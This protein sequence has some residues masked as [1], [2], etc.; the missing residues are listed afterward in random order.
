[1]THI[2]LREVKH[3]AMLARISFSK[4]ELTSLKR[5]LGGILAYVKKLQAMP[6]S[7]IAFESALRGSEAQA[8]DDDETKTLAS[9]DEMLESVPVRKGRLV[10]APKIRRA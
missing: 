4:D 5:D 8:R 6:R 2:T 7:S 9:A 10:K 3:S 1:M